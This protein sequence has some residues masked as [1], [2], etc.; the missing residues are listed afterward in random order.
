MTEKVHGRKRKRR[1]KHK[2]YQEFTTIS[3]RP[4]ASEKVVRPTAKD[5]ISNAK[6]ICEKFKCAPRT[7]QVDVES[8]QGLSLTSLLQKGGKTGIYF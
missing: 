7:R 3:L 4:V 6:S 1:E 5:V 8:L 2:L